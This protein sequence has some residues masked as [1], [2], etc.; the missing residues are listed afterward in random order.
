[1]PVKIKP[2]L[3]KTIQLQKLTKAQVGV[4]SCICILSAFF[5][6]A[7]AQVRSIAKAEIQPID[8]VSFTTTLD[9]SRIDLNWTTAHENNLSHFIVEQSIDGANYKKIGIVF[10][11]N[12][13]EGE[14][15]YKFRDNASGI[16]S[17][18][19]YYRLIFVQEDGKS[20][21]SYIKKLWLAK[22]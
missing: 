7:D 8:L 12:K 18:K 16:K 15:S 6:L 19:V 5:I 21:S 11:V 20:S 13:K 10:S 9:Q 1:M 22:S 14:Q 3:M 2:R 17:N 4:I